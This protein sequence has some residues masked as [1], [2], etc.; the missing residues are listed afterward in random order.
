M[1]ALK[2]RTLGESFRFA[3]QGWR[4]ALRSERNLRIH[5]AAAAAALLLGWLAGVGPERMALLVLTVALVIGAEL[6]N[7]A[8]ERAVDMWSPGRHPLAAAAKNVAAA[9][10]LTTAGAAVAVG[11]FVFRDYLTPLG[12]AGAAAGLAAAPRLAQRRLPTRRMADVVKLNE[13]KLLAEALAVRERAYV[14]HSGFKVGA[15]LLTASGRIFTGCNFEN[16]SLGATICA[17]RSAAA[18]AIAAGEREWVALAV[19]ADYPEP[20]PPCGICRQVL[21]EFAPDMPVIMANVAG[22]R[23]VMTVRELLPGMF[24]L[25]GTKG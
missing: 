10:V 1:A 4:D 18:A 22:Q 13:E 16:A 8:L 7:T 11:F 21:A 24:Q 20:V 6:F 3:L 17:E 12:A 2:A 9:A 14:P 5:V 19:V 15:A 23:R 25:D